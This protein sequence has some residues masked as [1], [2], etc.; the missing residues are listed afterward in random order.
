MNK[1]I[2]NVF[3]DMQTMTETWRSFSGLYYP[4]KVMI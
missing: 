2:D 1:N 3:T 4:M